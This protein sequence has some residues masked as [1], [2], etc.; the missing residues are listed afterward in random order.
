M[1]L[2]IN[3]PFKLFVQSFREL[4]QAKQRFCRCREYV[5]QG[6]IFRCVE[7]RDGRKGIYWF[8]LKALPGVFIEE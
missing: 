4:C 6:K 5:R 7:Q 2:A 8:L 3:Q 1:P